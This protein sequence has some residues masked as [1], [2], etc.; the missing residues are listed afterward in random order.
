M[1]KLGKHKIKSH[2]FRGNGVKFFCHNGLIFTFALPSN[3]IMK[4]KKN[5]NEYI[6][7]QDTGEITAYVNSVTFHCIA[8]I[9]KDIF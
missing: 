4:L 3:S 1:R 5:V 6:E 9:A 2:Q 7:I 8:N